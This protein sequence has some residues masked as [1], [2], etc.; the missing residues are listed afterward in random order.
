MKP[1]TTQATA[2]FLISIIS[3]TLSDQ[4]NFE[5][6][7]QNVCQPVVQTLQ[8]LIEGTKI[9]FLSL[10]FCIRVGGYR[11][12]VYFA[13]YHFLR[14]FIDNFCTDPYR[15]GCPQNESYLQSLPNYCD[16]IWKMKTRAHPDSLDGCKYSRSM[17]LRNCLLYLFLQLIIY[18]RHEKSACVHSTQE[19]FQEN[20]WIFQQFCWDFIT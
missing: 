8:L 9:T 19:F 1:P 20:S 10:A 3:E 2:F 11:L 6:S 12:M 17:I 16:R 18:Y 7:N 15:L 5:S 13:E 14:I 4:I